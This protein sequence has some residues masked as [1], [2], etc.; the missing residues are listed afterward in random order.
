MSFQNTKVSNLVLLW[1]WIE[2]MI[3][4]FTSGASMQAILN[5]KDYSAIE[6][7][8]SFVFLMICIES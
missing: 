2:S 1:I 4:D 8:D 3:Y 5:C 6:H 7:A